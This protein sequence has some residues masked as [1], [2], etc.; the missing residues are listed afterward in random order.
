[1]STRDSDS[2]SESGHSEKFGHG[3]QD[4]LPV[5]VNTTDSSTRQRKSRRPPKGIGFSSS[6]PFGS[7]ARQRHFQVAGTECVS[8]L[9]PSKQA[10]TGHIPPFL[11]HHTLFLEG[12]SLC[13]LGAVIME[14]P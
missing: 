8:Q 6:V 1:M 14:A 7:I 11:Q 12:R 5:E 13:H 4:F 9:T 3:P 2:D 10:V